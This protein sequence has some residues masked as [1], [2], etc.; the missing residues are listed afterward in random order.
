[1]LAPSSPAAVAAAG[2]RMGHMLRALTVTS[3]HSRAPNPGGQQERRSWQARFRTTDLPSW[4]L[5]VRSAC[6]NVRRPAV[7]YGLSRSLTATQLRSR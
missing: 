4:S 1:M 7:R 3:G 5:G 2:P 6:D